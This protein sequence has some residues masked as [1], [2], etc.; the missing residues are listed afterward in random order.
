V[1][2][3]A[4]SRPS[5][6]AARPVAA[7]AGAPCDGWGSRGTVL[8]VTVPVEPPVSPLVHPLAPAGRLRAAAGGAAAWLAA[9]RLPLLCVLALAAKQ[10]AVRL[11]IL[12][13]HHRLTPNGV[14][15]LLSVSLL[16]VAPVLGF[17]GAAR[18]LALAAAELVASVILLANAV[19][20]RQFADLPSAASLAYAG[21]AAETAGAIGLL[22]RR[23][24]ALLLFPLPLL[25]LLR[26]RLVRAAPAY[27]PRTALV[28]TLAAAAVFATV[29]AT[30]QAA[31]NAVPE[32]KSAARR[33]GPLGFNVFDAVGLAA[34]RVQRRFA[35]R[36]EILVQGRA[37]LGGQPPGPGT[38]HGAARGANVIIVQLESWQTFAV[39][40]PVAGGSLTP[41]FDRLARE[42][43]RFA[44]AYSQVSQ[45]NTSDAELAVLCSL[46]PPRAGS[47]YYEFSSNDLRCLPETLRDAGYATAV[48][49]GN[50]G[51]FWNRASIYPAIGFDRFDD[52][53]TF[54]PD[55]EDAWL[56]DE[57]FFRQLIPKLEGL[58]EPFLATVI[59]LTSHVPFDS[60]YVREHLSYGPEVGPVVARYLD[61]VRYTDQQLEI[62]LEGLRRTGLLERSV[63]IVYG[64][65]AGVVRGNSNV[66]EALGLRDDDAP[67]WFDAERRIPL[68]VRLPGGRGA[69]VPHVVA[70]VDLAPT[71]LGLVG[72]PLDG[73]AFLGRDVLGT[74]SGFVALPNGAASDDTLL[75]LDAGAT[76]GAGCY[77]R[78][79]GTRAPDAACGPIA[80]RARASL[81]L[82]RH[83]LELDLVG[84][85]AGMNGPSAPRAAPAR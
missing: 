51:G 18:V 84:R 81:E 29:A 16:F 67:G 79:D 59:S 77:R 36:D 37:Y 15:S 13:G 76:L 63:L 48:F 56:S 28:A 11:E 80:D 3:P 62:L 65:H 8:L 83:L 66:G 78:S 64:D 69:Q 73:T 70:Q 49:H 53:S 6:G 35:P 30:T 47:A 12:P 61:S 23:T 58:R 7:R 21:Q 39:G 9:N 26:P 4:S 27:R 2:E 74:G 20:F 40:Y 42:S 72:L 46:Y 31:R 43:L 22:L 44:G 34:S 52:L 14:L 24:D 82:S 45:G 55:A 60:P 1:V 10:Y 71:I 32:R 85:L 25:A 54:V 17:R 5:G 38:L 33:F 41:T 19:Y 75:Y 68:L 57:S 50:R